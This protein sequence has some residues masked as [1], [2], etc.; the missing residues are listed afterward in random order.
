MALET[1]E[2]PNVRY[3]RH[4]DWRRDRTIPWDLAWVT[5]TLTADL[6]QT[7]KAGTCV[8]SKHSTR[9]CWAE[10]QSRLA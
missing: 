3:E 9:Q 7:L 8:Y 10:L 5:G 2:L 1:I 6:G 4:S